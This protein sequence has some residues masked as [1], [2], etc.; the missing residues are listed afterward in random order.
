MR[1]PYPFKGLWRWIAL[2]SFLAVGG[3]L[4]GLLEGL[5]TEQSFE[6]AFL[7]MVLFD[8][9]K[10]AI[11]GVSVAAG[12]RAVMGVALACMLGALSGWSHYTLVSVATTFPHA[13]A[14]AGGPA[15]MVLAHH[16]YLRGRIRW[17]KG[18]CLGGVLYPLASAAGYGLFLW[19]AREQNM[20]VSAFA[21]WAL[22]EGIGSWLAMAIAIRVSERAAP[23]PTP[24][25]PN[26]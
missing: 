11:E 3:A 1:D 8:G 23:A 19:A 9:V 22:E 18:W 26:A 6:A 13:L 7:N 15:L 20:G 12:R 5:R 14:S 4:D 16:L 24:P 17:R 2:P 21:F 25:A 10:G